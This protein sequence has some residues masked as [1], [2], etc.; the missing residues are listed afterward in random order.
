MVALAAALGVAWVFVELAM[1]TPFAVMYAVL[2]RAIRRAASD[3]KG[4]ANDVA[5]SLGWACAWATIYVVPI[6]AIT[7]AAHAIHR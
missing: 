6:A 1:P 4:C 3:R 5:R 7:W 2:M